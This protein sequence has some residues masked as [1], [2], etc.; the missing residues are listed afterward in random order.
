MTVSD[1]ILSNPTS[2]TVNARGVRIVHVTDSESRVESANPFSGKD[3]PVVVPYPAGSRP[4][5]DRDPTCSG[6][7]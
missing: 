5:R 1:R 3:L 6:R 4:D 7:L 2:K